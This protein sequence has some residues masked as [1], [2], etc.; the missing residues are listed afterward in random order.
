M[1]VY[2]SDKH[3]FIYIRQPRASSSSIL[4]AIQRLYCGGTG[5]PDE[6]FRQ[7]HNIDDAT[8]KAYFVFTVVRNPIA[9]M[10]STFVFFHQ[11]LPLYTRTENSEAPGEACSITFPAFASD[12]FRMRDICDSHG[13]CVYIA[14]M[15]TWVVDFVNAHISQQAHL[16]F[17]PA[18]ESIVD[19]IGRTENIQDDWAE[20]VANIQTRSGLDVGTVAME[21][22][23]GRHT[24]IEVPPEEQHPCL[25]ADRVQMKVLEPPAI[26]A[27][28]LQHAL[29][30]RLFSFLPEE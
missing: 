10:L 20:I 8:W 27:I 24:A 30:F 22:V 18:G 3:K 23:N 1:Q 7:A 4:A 21:N 5:C 15:N 13:C 17:T 25:P 6:I 11:E 12:S 29:D 19:Y 26:L 2:I 9:R 14:A 28:T 16:V